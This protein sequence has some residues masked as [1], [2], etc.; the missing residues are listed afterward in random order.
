MS[1]P[2]K[3][4]M[5]HDGRLTMAIAVTAAFVL[6]SMNEVLFLNLRLFNLLSIAMV[7]ITLLQ[8]SRF[9]AGRPEG[10][11][12][13]AYALLA[14]VFLSGINIKIR[15]K[16]FFFMALL[17][18]A[19][20]LHR[21]F[22]LGERFR[23]TI[24]LRSLTPLISFSL[25]FAL[26]SLTITATGALWVVFSLTLTLLAVQLVDLLCIRSSGQSTP[27]HGGES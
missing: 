1:E 19:I 25:A 21:R 22:V 9:R 20:A 16:A 8:L 15:P 13:C 4:S 23:R 12:A 3:A 7:C 10:T 6:Y 17:F 14:L 2:M 27:A 26:F 11:G 24:P 18:V 5:R